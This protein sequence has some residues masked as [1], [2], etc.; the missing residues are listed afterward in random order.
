MVKGVNSFEAIKY[1][2]SYGENC[3]ATKKDGVVTIKGDKNGVRQMELDE[4]MECLAKDQAKKYERTPEKDTVSFS[5]KEEVQPKGKTN[6][7]KV[8]G[9]LT[10]A[11]TAAAF[12]CK[13]FKNSGLKSFS[14]Y[15]TLIAQKAG[16]ATKYAKG[17]LGVIGLGLPLIGLGIGAIVDKMVNKNKQA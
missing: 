17:A 5:G 15:I 14:N 3:V 12:I 8:L 2:T 10:G 4:F 6:A 16:I 7:G 9:T 13:S 1:Q 11:G